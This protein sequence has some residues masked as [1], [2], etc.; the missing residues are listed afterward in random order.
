MLK[1]SKVDKK[2]IGRALGLE[3]G[4]EIL[5]FDGV[6]CVDELDYTYALSSPSFTMQVRDKRGEQVYDLQVEKAENESLG[7]E[8]EKQEEL[9]TCHNRC[10][11]CFVDQMPKG[12][13]ETLYVK[14]DDYTMSFACGNFVT[15]TNLTEEELQRIIRLKIS[16]LYISVQTMNPTLRCTLLRNR[17]AGK[18]V[19]QVER[20]AEGGIEMHCQ[21]VLVP[22]L[23][24]GEEL[25]YTARKLFEHYPQVKDLA[26]VPTGLTK[27]REGLYPIDD[28][29]EEYCNKLLDLVDSLN[30]QFGVN[31]LLPADEYFI[32][33]KRAVKPAE[34]YGEF[35]QIE[36][37]IGLTRKFIDE[38]FKGLDNLPDKKRKAKRSLLISGVSAAKL[39]GQLLAAAT[40]KINGLQAEVLPIVN[41]FFGESV[42]CTGLLTG[43]DIVAAVKKYQ[44]EKGGVDEVI[45]PADTLKEFEDIFLCG[46]TL[47]EMQR[48]LPKLRVRVNR[49]GGAGLVEILSRR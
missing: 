34:F 28:V 41:D 24:D 49:D 27:Y 30:E 21:A 48:A 37:G 40:K 32:R 7:V 19:E 13:R 15:L 5:S 8:F 47:K 11:F 3:K 43:R 38:F 36:N 16:P 2:G 39:N 23:N 46:M 18:I 25:A 42:T 1:I 10:L 12:L 31:F 4:D 17:F 6:P 35:A 44:E 9:R 45:L 33:A 29:D 26:C 22:G 20:L 14:D